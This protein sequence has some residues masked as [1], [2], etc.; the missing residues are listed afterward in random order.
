MEQWRIFILD[1][2]DYLMPFFSRINAE[3]VCAYASRTLLFL[4]SD[5]TLKPLVIE[6]SLPGFSRGTTKSRIIL[7]ASHGTEA[8]LWHLAKAHVTA[9]D[10]A[11][12]QLVSHCDATLKPLVIELSLPGFSRGTTKSRIILP[13]SHGTEA[14][15]WHLA[16]AHVTANDYAYH[17]LVSH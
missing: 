11:Y 12:H 2:H 16:K 10:Y 15:L 4:R 6:L 8:A 17:Q 5:A 14:A 7:P 13:A 1:H 3:G 9:N